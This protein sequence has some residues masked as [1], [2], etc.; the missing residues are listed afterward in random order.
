MVGTAVK[1]KLFLSL[2]AFIMMVAFQNCSEQSFSSVEESAIVT[3]TG[4]PNCRRVLNTIKT[5]VEMIFLVDTSGSNVGKN[6]TD[7][8]Q[9]VRVGSMQ[10][11]LNSY[12]DRTNFK[13]SFTDFADKDA[14]THM[15][16][17]GWSEM[18]EAIDWLAEGHDSGGTPYVAALDEA[19][20][21]IAG[22]TDRLAN[23]KYVVVFLSDGMPDPKVEDDVLESEIQN[24]LSA[25]PGQVS[26]NTVYYG[27]TN[28]G[29]SNRLRMMA[30]VGNGNFL[31]T[32]ANGT[33]NVFNI[34]DLVQ[35]PGETC[36]L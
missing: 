4:G 22:D 21:I 7:P 36:D 26:L 28:K 24:M 31:D 30:A 1:F 9:V 19:H 14:T 27:P 33:G 17:S 25:V 12:K 11:F 5:P 6:G 2:P 3:D 10:R 23:T 34:S 29:A 13:W 35:V 20:A 32:N 8:N 18:Q 15:A 16:S